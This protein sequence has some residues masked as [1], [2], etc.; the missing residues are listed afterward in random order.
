MGP[1]ASADSQVASFLLF[2]L[3]KVAVKQICLK[4]EPSEEI[5]TFGSHCGCFIPLDDELGFPRS[6]TLLWCCTETNPGASNSSFPSLN[7]S[8]NFDM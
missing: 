8:L 2:S 1:A 4:F 6:K 5:W 3:I 7:S